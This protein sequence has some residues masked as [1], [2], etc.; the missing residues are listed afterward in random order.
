MQANAQQKKHPRKLLT[1]AR[2]PSY[3]SAGISNTSMYKV[4]N[5]IWPSVRS[6]ED[7]GASYIYPLVARRFTRS[8]ADLASKHDRDEM[9]DEFSPCVTVLVRRNDVR[10]LLDK[11]FDS[12][13]LMVGKL[14]KMWQ[15]L[16]TKRC[17]MF[18]AH[19]ANKHFILCWWVHYYSI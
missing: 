7:F 16:V 9:V 2:F 14:V 15:C 10:F 5:I 11:R 1:R 6:P 19:V 4:Q 17:R 8:P 3:S 12:K 13:P 18:A